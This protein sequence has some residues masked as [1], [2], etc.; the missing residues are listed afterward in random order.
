MHGALGD[1]ITGNIWIALGEAFARDPIK[2]AGTDE[3]LVRLTYT[4]DRSLK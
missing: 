1:P 4:T 3:L 2:Q